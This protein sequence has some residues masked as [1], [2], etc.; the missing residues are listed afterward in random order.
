[1]STRPAQYLLRFDDLCPTMDRARWERY[2]RLIR[3]FG[4]CP[5]L[6]VVPE[7]YD[8][9]LQRDA[10]DAG[11]WAAMGQLEAA[12]ATIGLHGY[13]HLCETQG[14]RLIPLHS[15]TEFAGVDEATQREWVRSGIARLRVEGLDPR[16]WV[17]PRHGFDLATLRALR[18][19][20]I[21]TVSDGFAE[22]PFRAHGAMWI[23]Q[24]LWEPLEKQSGLWT[25]CLH[26]NS[27]TD[28]QV[29]SLESFLERFSSQFTS[30]DRV[31]AEWPFSPRTA[32]DRIFHARL[33][34]RIRI[35]RL[36]RRLRVR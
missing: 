34:L 22:A 35:A 24:Q 32:A 33:L 10:P 18:E 36:R 7:N 25:I 27:A 21:E 23:P 2:L 5:I 26:A 20:G 28:D 16:I 9:D 6:A 17:A 8:P 12:G 1:V 4:L 13:K 31:L 29:R 15:W 19:A 11:F 30:V 3:R 14:R